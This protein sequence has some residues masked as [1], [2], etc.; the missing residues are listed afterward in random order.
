[1]PRPEI[2]G[3]AVVK[4]NEAVTL[5]DRGIK[6]PVLLMGP[7]DEANLRE[8]VARAIMPMVYTPIGDVL[9]REAAQAGRAIPIHVCVDTGIGRVGISAHAPSRRQAP[10]LG[11]GL[12]EPPCAGV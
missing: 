8:M 6:K 5:R 12:A 7:F 10:R 11:K 2:A 3:L 1:M 9:E 4:L